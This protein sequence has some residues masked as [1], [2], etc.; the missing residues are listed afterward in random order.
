MNPATLQER[1]AAL[2][3]RGAARLEPVRFHALESL[4]RRLPA[5]SADVQAVLSGKLQA[6][7]GECE[8]RLAPYPAQPAPPIRPA[9]RRAAPVSP[10]APLNQQLRAAAAARALGA[11]GEPH[12]PDEL[13]SAH[14]FRQAWSRGHTLDRLAQALARRP[15]QSGP[16]NSHALV[17]QSLAM[18]RELSPDY[19][20]R[21]V[22]YAESL[23]WLE[24][25]ATP[26]ARESGKPAAKTARR[27]RAK[28]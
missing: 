11:A 25:A 8:Q 19:L 22:V 23:Q 14:R 27:G 13:A 15:A 1:I 28:K 7:L 24:Q 26:D 16:L 18:M 2:R 6:A 4:A 12:D 10:L 3:A 5:Q 20:R 21:F 9:A 17:L